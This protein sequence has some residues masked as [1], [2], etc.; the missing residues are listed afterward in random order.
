MECSAIELVTRS[1]AQK[2]NLQLCAAQ[3]VH[4]GCMR[5]KGQARSIDVNMLIYETNRVFKKLEGF[6]DEWCALLQKDIYLYPALILYGQ[7]SCMVNQRL[8]SIGYKIHQ[9]GLSRSSLAQRLRFVRESKID[10]ASSTIYL[11]LNASCVHT[12]HSM[13]CLGG[14]FTLITSARTPLDLG[15]V[16]SR[17]SMTR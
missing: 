1:S 7:S 6:F 14:T 3:C 13:P 2:E 9:S 16:L 5:L 10:D 17:S 15:L 4:A 11:L 12:C 8:T